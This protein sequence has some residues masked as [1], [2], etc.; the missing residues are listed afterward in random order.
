MFASSIDPSD[1]GKIAIMRHFANQQLD[2]TSRLEST[3]FHR[4]EEID[5]VLR[6]NFVAYRYNPQTQHLIF[7]RPV[8]VQITRHRPIVLNTNNMN[9][10]V[11]TYA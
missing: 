7:A 4:F 9:A 8:P 6:K 2:T 11:N 1:N 3:P 10:R 5:S